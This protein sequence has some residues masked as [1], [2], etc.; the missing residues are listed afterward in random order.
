M[1]PLAHYEQVFADLRKNTPFRDFLLEMAS[2]QPITLYR[3]SVGVSRY[4]EI[5]VPRFGNIVES[6]KYEDLRDGL[7][8]SSETARTA[9]PLFEAMQ[10]LFLTT[11]IPAL[12]SA[13]NDEN[14]EFADCAGHT[15]NAYLSIIANHG[16][17][18]LYSFSIKSADNVYNSAAI[19]DQ[20]ENIY[21]SS[22]VT[23]SSNIFY[24]RYLDNCN[25]IWF[26]RNMIGCVECIFCEGLQNQSYC[27]NNK[28]FEKEEYF[29][30]KATI[31]AQKCEFERWYASMPKD[32]K[33]LSSVDSTGTFVSMCENVKNGYSVYHV[34][35]SYNAIFTG[36][37]SEK[38]DLYDT[39][40]CGATGHMY[41]TLNGKLFSEYVFAS[42]TITKSTHI[43]YSYHLIDCSY[44]IGCIGLRNRSY[45]IYNEQYSREE[46]E[47]LADQ[48][49]SAMERDKTFGKF[50][51]ATI[52]PFYF[53]DT[54]AHF[55]DDSFTHEE[56]TEKGFLW[57]DE[58]IRADIPA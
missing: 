23:G 14:S 49:F 41:A 26:S 13:K 51:P 37:K 8:R 55:I 34:K 24:S 16:E 4:P 22:G 40:T 31:L 28:I 36:G 44:C 46:W 42:S 43:F 39:V 7:I 21:S 45:C 17:N 20:C 11:P 58:A 9:R 19:W 35:D 57:R 38:T 18:M 1:N 29:A 12:F 56:V 15:K 2:W 53:N 48:I 54:L 47:I 50:F 30:K 5:S 32:S 3:R 33:N 6:S 27:I 52:N 10:E 25:N